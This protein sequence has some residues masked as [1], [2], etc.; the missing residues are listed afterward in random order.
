MHVPANIFILLLGIFL[1]YIGANY[2]VRGSANLGRLLG[3]RPIIIGLTVVAFGTSMPE[4]MVSMFGV[5]AGA[6][7]ISVG[8][9][10]GS[11][12]A[13]IGLILGTAGLIAPITLKYH[14]IREQLIILFL[15]SLLFTLL[16][17]N[18]ISRLEGLFF[19]LI[20]VGYVVYL[21]KSSRDAEAVKEL[22]EKDNSIPRNILFSLGGILA[23]VFAS[24]GI[25]ESATNI[26]EHFG[27]SQTVIGMT[28]VALGTSLPELAASIMAQIKNESDISIG[29]IIGSNLFN[30]FFVGGGTAAIGGLPVDVSIYGFEVPFMLVFTMLLF[31]VIFARKG[32]HRGHAGIFLALYLSFI[33]ISYLWR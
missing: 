32:I 12:I 21:T 6:P 27:I 2:L 10:I 29:N 13:N 23:L 18:G 7:D 26:A 1:L 22:P 17:Y 3:I 20:I 15:G 33:A 16:A 5:L 30:M 11:N 4:F 9:I 8:N 14:N 19:I 24:R 25:I 31:P 28:V